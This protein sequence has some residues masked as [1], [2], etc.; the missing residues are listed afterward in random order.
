MAR[1]ALVPLV[2]IA[3]LAPLRAGAADAPRPLRTLSFDCTVSIADRRE[4]PGDSRSSHV[5][6]LGRT[7]TGI[8][9]TTPTGSGETNSSTTAEAK[10][11]ISVAVLS[12]TDDAGLVVEVAENADQRTRPKVKIALGP[13]GTLFYDPANAA[14]LTEEEVAVVR[15]LA[16]GFY[17]DRPREPGTSWTVDQSANGHVDVEHYR[18]LSRDRDRVTLNYALEEKAAGAS[19]YDA[20]REGSLVYDT[21]L[22]V[23][24]KVTFQS[25]SRRQLG[26]TM[27]TTRSTI[28][29]TLTADS[30]GPPRS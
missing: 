27:S 5:V 11:S 25:S 21:A 20:T 18:V 14:N 7:S 29:L 8:V 1:R 16:R 24:V 12:A 23:P 28:T 15:W 26:A 22:V 3:V 19:G 4:T 10:G 2:V 13:D 17:G 6:M 9:E 30:F